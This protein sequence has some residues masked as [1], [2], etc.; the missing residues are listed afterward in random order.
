MARPEK[1]DLE[2]RQ[3]SGAAGAPAQVFRLRNKWLQVAGVFDA[4]LYLEGTLGDHDFA[5]LGPP[6]VGPGFVSV[7]ETVEFVRV[8]T[9]AYHSGEPAVTLA[10]FDERAQ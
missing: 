1:V 5:P 9:A 6:L 4:E 3:E 7:P 10:G 8:R 2:V